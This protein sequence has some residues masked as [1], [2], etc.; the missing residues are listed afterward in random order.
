MT[1]TPTGPAL[2]ER[3]VASFRER[4]F[5]HV[6][7]VLEP[8]EVERFREA[9]VAFR[10]SHATLGDQAQFAQYV[11]VGRAD[12][13]LAE[14]VH[15]PRLAAMA[16]QLAGMPL[17]IWHDQVLVKD[18]HN[19]S[20]TEYHQDG[21]FWPH[22]DCRRA[23]S[24]WVALVDV[25][26]ERGS[27]TFIPGSQSEVGLPAQD[28]TDETSLMRLW[29]EGIYRERVT[30]PLRAGDCTFH[31]SYTAHTA[32]AN[33]TDD[34]RIAQVIIYVDADATFDGRPHPV[35]DGLGLVPG[36]VLPDERFP[37]I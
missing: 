33:D 37:R 36:T 34:P 14:L 7:Q 15:H 3:T 19:G 24:A 2:T 16:R 1:T 21:Q 9:V 12:T 23:L 32:N 11:D 4:G 28:L 6:P 18:P 13:T 20:P 27:M 22:G 35:T 5:V 31:D 8:R 26:V 30:V 29:P 25:P 10:R 17:R